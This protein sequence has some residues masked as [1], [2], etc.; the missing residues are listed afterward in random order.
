MTN[1]NRRKNRI[2]KREEHLRKTSSGVEM[3]TESYV[4]EIM[5]R[6]GLENYESHISTQEI[7]VRTNFSNWKVAHD[8]K[9][10]VLYHD[11]K[12]TI[13]ARKIRDKYHKQDVFYNLNQCIK[14]IGE[15]E[16]FKKTEWR[17]QQ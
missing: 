6:Y 9:I 10:V 17:K 15:H 7:Y 2:D 14:T 5:K 16:K 12:I 3:W 1:N 11:S 8:S 4:E 13:N